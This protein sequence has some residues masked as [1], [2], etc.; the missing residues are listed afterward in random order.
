MLASFSSTASN[1][2]G[3]DLK[4]GVNMMDVNGDGLVDLVIYAKFDNNTSHPNKTMTIFMK[5]KNG[6]YNIVPVPNDAGFT[7]FDFSL[8]AS[9]TKIT[10]FKLYK[11]SNGFFVVRVHKMANKQNGEDVS[12]KLPV[13]LSRYD[14]NMDQEIPGN[15]LFYW[16]LTKT[17][18]TKEHYGDVD[19][20][21]N[22]FNKV[23]D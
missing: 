9:T 17:Y 19:E 10:D 7:W 23:L 15:P 1:H 22:H 3:I 18:V 5:N 14:I 11:K 6:E 8:S 21:F 16:G 4:W 12:D 2:G 20:A 13:K